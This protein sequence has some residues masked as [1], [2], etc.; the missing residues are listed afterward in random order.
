MLEKFCG[1]QKVEK[2]RNSLFMSDCELLMP[3]GAGPTSC[4]ITVV[5]VKPN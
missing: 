2:A 4:N 5:L 1:N 3:S